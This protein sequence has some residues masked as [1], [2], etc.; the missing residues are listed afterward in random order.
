MFSRLFCAIALFVMLLTVALIGS[1]M[2]R[3]YIIQPPQFE[4]GGHA[5]GPA[6]RLWA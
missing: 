3:P 1:T 5:F 6:G 4:H 2:Y